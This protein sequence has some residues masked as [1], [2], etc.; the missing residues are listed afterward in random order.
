MSYTCSSYGSNKK[1]EQKFIGK[2]PWKAAKWNA[3]M[4][5]EGYFEDES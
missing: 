1:E 5:V 2:T 3:E 4:E